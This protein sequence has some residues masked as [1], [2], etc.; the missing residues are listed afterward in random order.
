MLSK[1]RGMA[2]AIHAPISRNLEKYDCIGNTLQVGRFQP[3]VFSP[4]YDSV[5]HHRGL[6]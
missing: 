3:A 2:G 4:P 6:P 1:I 5:G